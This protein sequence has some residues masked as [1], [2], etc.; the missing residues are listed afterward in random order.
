MTKR[1]KTSRWNGM[2]LYECPYC[3]YNSTTSGAVVDTHITSQH[4]DQIRLDN[5]VKEN[6]RKAKEG[7]PSA[8]AS[9]T[10]PSATVT[11]EGD[12]K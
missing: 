2:T 9:G 12:N 7:A 10:G 5:L 3:P 4:A 1:M 8:A 11:K 6:E